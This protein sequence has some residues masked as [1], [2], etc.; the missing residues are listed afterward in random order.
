MPRA[1][2]ANATNQ[3]EVRLKKPARKPAV[4]TDGVFLN[5]AISPRVRAG[6]NKLVEAMELAGQRQ[7][8]E[9]LIVDEIHRRNL[10]MPRAA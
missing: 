3:T 9:K 2:K 6:L 1:K 4:V 5:V 8:L 10:R 7:V